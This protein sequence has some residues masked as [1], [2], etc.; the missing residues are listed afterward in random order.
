MSASRPYVI[1]DEDD[2]A[3]SSEVDLLDYGKLRLAVRVPKLT[4]R[5]DSDTSEPEITGVFTRKDSSSGR[6]ETPVKNGSIQ[7]PDTEIQRFKLGK[8]SDITPGDTV[9]L[10]DTSSHAADAMHSGDF[11]RIKHII[12]DL[13]TDEVR[14]RGYRLR[15]TK[16]LG[17]V[18]D[19]K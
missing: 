9:E 18:F 15:R 11:L 17:Q 12:M 16:Y 8:G 5:P 3:A 1:S 13:E 10:I 4:A 2:E 6:S 19:C 14:L 7:L